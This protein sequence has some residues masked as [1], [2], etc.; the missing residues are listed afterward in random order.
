MKQGNNQYEWGH[1]NFKHLSFLAYHF[2]K[3]QM[4]LTERLETSESTDEVAG[5][6]VSAECHSINVGSMQYITLK[7][8]ST[9]VP[10]E[11][12]LGVNSFRD[13][14]WRTVLKAAL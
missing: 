14:R 6:Y 1:F 10:A 4:T 9:G 11:Y 2:P 5:Y 7:N 13:S 3:T 8:K 12:Q